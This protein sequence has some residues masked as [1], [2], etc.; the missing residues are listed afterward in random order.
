MRS[1]YEAF[2]HLCKRSAGHAN[3]KRPVVAVVTDYLPPATRGGAMRALNAMLEALCNDVEFHII[4]RDHD[5]LTGELFDVAGVGRWVEAG[6]IRV[7]RLPRESLTVETI[8]QAIVALRPDMIYANSLFSRLTQRVLWARW[9]GRIK[10]ILLVIAPEGELD[11][12]ALA[13]KPWRKRIWL[14]L[15]RRTGLIAGVLWKAANQLEAAAIGQSVPS[16]IATILPYLPARTPVPG[17]HNRKVAGMLRLLFLSRI[18]RKKNLGFLLELLRTVSARTELTIVGPVEDEAH[19][20]ECRAIIGSLPSTVSVVYAGPCQ[21]EA[22]WSYYQNADAFVLPTLGENYGYVIEDALRAGCPPVISDRTPWQAIA[23]G[24][25][26]FVLPLEAGRWTEV[27]TYLAA[28]DETQHSGLRQ[29][30]VDVLSSKD[31][32]TGLAEAYV[33]LFRGK[34]PGLLS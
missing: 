16:A 26:G 10:G 25:A 12:G 17:N 15:A 11:A 7:L 4:T 22:V 27:L 33:E 34:H 14:E 30:A 8:T 6:A 13:I 32:G 31:T 23:D 20:A 21:P 29:R 5:A 2:R 9:R 19:W 24:G 28:M 1:A 3:M 18:S